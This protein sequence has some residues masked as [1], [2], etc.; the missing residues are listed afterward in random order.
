MKY[1]LFIQSHALAVE[2]QSAVQFIDQIVGI[3]RHIARVILICAIPEKVGL[4]LVS[5]LLSW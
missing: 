3:L 2:F 5:D 4:I 1:P